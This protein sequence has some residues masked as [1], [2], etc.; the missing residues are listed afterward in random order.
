MIET[1]SQKHISNMFYENQ[2]KNELKSKKQKRQ[3]EK[4]L[5]R[6][7]KENE[8]VY[9]L[10][11]KETLYFALVAITEVIPH[12]ISV[13]IENNVKV[14]KNEEEFYLNFNHFSNLF[15]KYL[16]IPEGTEIKGRNDFLKYKTTFPKIKDQ[17]EKFNMSKKAT[18]QENFT[19]E[20]MHFS[21]LLNE[22]CY[23]FEKKVEISLKK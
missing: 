1:A 8:K 15:N 20:M 6:M 13:M 4:I 3:E 11:R 14:R 7:M 16:Q 17:M 23:M 2:K 18:L 10:R 12:C 22:A 5:K 19:L 21:K 9:Q